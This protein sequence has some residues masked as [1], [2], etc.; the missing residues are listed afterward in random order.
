M[1]GVAV[2]LQIGPGSPEHFSAWIE[3]NIGVAGLQNIDKHMAGGLART[4]AADHH[5]VEV[6]PVP[7]HTGLRTADG[8]VLGHN[9]VF[10]GVLAVTVFLVNR[11]GAAPLCATVLLTPPKVHTLRNDDKHRQSVDEQA[12]Q[13]TAQGSYTK[14]KVE[15]VSYSPV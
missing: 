12:H 8:N 15:W 4:A 11:P 5:G 3:D 7:V 2:F 14:L 9:K 1:D 6:S 10:I 13:H